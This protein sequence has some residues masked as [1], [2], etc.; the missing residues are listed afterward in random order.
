MKDLINR[1]WDQEREII[2]AYY[3]GLGEMLDLT[4]KIK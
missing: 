3:R 1:N 4:A 2:Q